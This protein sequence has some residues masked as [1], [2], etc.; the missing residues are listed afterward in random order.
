MGTVHPLDGQRRKVQQGNAL[1]GVRQTRPVL[2]RHVRL[3][4]EQARCFLAQLDGKAADAD[5]PTAMF[6]LGRLM[7]HTATLLDVVDTTTAFPAAARGYGRLAGEPGWRWRAGRVLRCARRLSCR[8]GLGSWQEPGKLR[9]PARHPGG[10]AG[11]D[12]L[13]HCLLV[14]A[15]G[16]AVPGAPGRPH[17]VPQL[18]GQQVPV[19][20]AHQPGFVDRVAA[21]RYRAPA[22]RRH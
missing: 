2:D 18:P 17:L 15:A 13:E 11:R 7:E 6:L 5:L 21:A 14:L 19:A 3:C 1:A 22:R 9:F 10:A 8:C 4:V 16:S 20:A 12:G